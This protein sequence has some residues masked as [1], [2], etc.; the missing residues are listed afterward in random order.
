MT[1]M[2]LERKGYSVLSAATAPSGEAIEGAKTH[3][4]NAGD[5]ME[6]HRLM[7]QL[8][9]RFDQLCEILNE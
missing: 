2:M 1:R 9:N 5:V 8:E 7:S 3:A 6:L 4:G